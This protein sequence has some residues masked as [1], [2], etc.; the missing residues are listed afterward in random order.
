MAILELNS[1]AL[2]YNFKQLNQYFGK[3]NKHWGVV[4]KMLC[5]NALFLQEVLNLEPE[6]VFDSRLSNLEA[7]RKLRPDIQTAYIK[8]P[9]KRSLKKLLK[10]ADISFNTSVETIRAINDLAGTLGKT[11]QVVIMI[12]MGDLREGV[13]REDFVSF[14]GSIFELPHIEVIGIGA[15]LN[16]LNGIMPS[17]DKL[18]QLSLYKELVEAKFGKKIPWVSAGTSVTLPM[19]PK[20]LVP[21][22]MNHFRVGETL[23]FGVDLFEHKRFRNLRED[24][25]SLKAEIIEIQEKPLQPSGPRG[26]NLQGEVAEDLPDDFSQTS[27]RALVDIGLLDIDLDNIVPRH[28]DY[29]IDGASSDIVVLDVGSNPS[30]LKVGDYIDFKVNYMGA[31]RLL[32]S[33]YVEKQVKQREIR[34]PVRNS[35]N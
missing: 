30:R 8:P 5:G 18:I 28:T 32:N 11:H 4:T 31:L 24:V 13:M 21:K 19:L 16:C 20:K 2:K 1:E 23:F 10:V 14:Y 9:P 25:F 3:H 33:Y 17:H 7:V 12:E 22:G 34:V 29:R 6:T 35:P 26:M 15:N 27:T